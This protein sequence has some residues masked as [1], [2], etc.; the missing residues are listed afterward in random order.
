[1]SLE[2]VIIGSLLVI[3]AVAAAVTRYLRVP[4][5][6]ALVCSPD[7]SWQISEWAQIHRLELQGD[8]E[9]HVVFEG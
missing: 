5:P 1:M 4:Y 7:Y 3:S 2:V 6:V 9:L 8:E